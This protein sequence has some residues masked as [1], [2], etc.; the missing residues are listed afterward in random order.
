MSASS[1]V[2]WTA[3]GAAA[4][5]LAPPG[6]RLTREEMAELV[7][8]LRSAARQA[9]DPVAATAQLDDPGAGSGAEPGGRVL[10]VDRAGWARANAASFGALVDPVIEEA[11]ER[12]QPTDA[13]EASPA[14]S[15]P[16]LSSPLAEAS[17][18]L[19]AAETGGVLAFLAT[20]VLGQ[21]DVLDPG[22]GRLLLVA[23][24]VATVEAEIGAVPADFRLWV[25]LHEETHRL[26]F[27][28]ANWLA[29]WLTAEVRELVSDVL[30]EP[31][32]TL[33]RLVEAVAQLP[34]VLRGGG[35]TNGAL[36]SPGLVD[37][38]QTPEQRARLDG[39]T[40]VMSLLEG[41]ADVV[42]DEVGPT[43]VPSV[44][45]IRARFDARRRSRSPLDR[46]FRRLIGLE[47]KAA[48]YRNGAAFVRGVTSRVG[49]SGFNAVWT[50][51]QS[52][53][54]AA[55]LRDPAA[56]VARVHG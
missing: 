26:Q 35:G 30:S 14:L 3:A 36:P 16:A 20:K 15:S 13:G 11:L 22:G 42:M 29:Q 37:L 54:S 43:V 21:Y 34:G 50:S 53:P 38:V 51:P 45:Q 52:L 12:R 6:P 44:A 7:D 56:W 4:A 55:E 33:Q 18:L 28:A 46:A 47:A 10:V 5:A 8:E 40:A 19:S 48:Q 1:V 32:T 2:D 49:V 39:V 9:R 27:A 24:N 41:H 17:R 23:P 31:A 25:C